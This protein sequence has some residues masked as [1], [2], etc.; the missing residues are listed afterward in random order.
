M[1]GCDAVAPTAIA[2]N[3]QLLS[4]PDLRTGDPDWGRCDGRFVLGVKIGAV[5]DGGGGSV[6]AG[7]DLNSRAS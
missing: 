5:T 6:M 7:E 3:R 1:I 2:S 4:S